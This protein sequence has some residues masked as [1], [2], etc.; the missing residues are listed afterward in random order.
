MHSA[1]IIRTAF[2]TAMLAASGMALSFSDAQSLYKTDE[3]SGSLVDSAVNHFLGDVAEQGTVSSQTGFI[4]KA[5]GPF[6]A[7]NY[8]V[9]N[10]GT[11]NRTMWNGEEDFGIAL[12]VKLLSSSPSISEKFVGSDTGGYGAPAWSIGVSADTYN[13]FR[14][15]TSISGSPVACLIDIGYTPTTDTWF[16]IAASYQANNKTGYFTI[17]NITDSASC[18]LNTSARGFEL[19]VG[20]NDI[21]GQSAS[22]FYIE[23]L[24]FWNLSFN[25]ANLDW[26]YNGG[27]GQGYGAPSIIVSALYPDNNTVNA[28]DNSILFGYNVTATESI[29][30]CSLILDGTVNMTDTSVANNSEGSFLAHGLANGTHGWSVTCAGT[31]SNSTGTRTLTVAVPHPFAICYEAS[32]WYTL[33]VVSE[34]KSYSVGDDIIITTY[35]NGNYSLFTADGDPLDF[36][37]DQNLTVHNYVAR[38]QGGY[39]VVFTCGGS[40]DVETFSIGE[41]GSF[42]TGPI[43]AVIIAFTALIALVILMRR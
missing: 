27:G 17:D 4:N 25:Q 3:S 40:S 28:T 37:T 10:Y 31:F 41:P 23:Q 39:Y 18:D 34:K 11:G 29:I 21:G 43:A 26:L 1:E 38:T 24:S 8:F 19:S 12:W 9:F 14:L 13:K 20:A 2:M 16:F 42:P 32:P 33:L 5:R 7:S 15:G 35:G 6:S 30:N 22:D 36:S